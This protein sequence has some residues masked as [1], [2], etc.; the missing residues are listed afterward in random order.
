[1]STDTD[2]ARQ[3]RDAATLPHVR[4]AVLTPAQ[5][6]ARLRTTRVRSGQLRDAFNQ[7]A[8][9]GGYTEPSSTSP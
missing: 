6:L 8:A 4:V 2:T 3:T 5:Y 7:P 9:P 1:M